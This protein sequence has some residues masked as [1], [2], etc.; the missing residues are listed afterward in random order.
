MFPASI[1]LFFQIE[2]GEYKKLEQFG[3]KYVKIADFEN[4]LK[5]ID[6]RLGIR[7][8][9]PHK[10]FPELEKLASVTVDG[11]SLF[12]I[13]NYD[14]YDE[15]NESYGVDVRGDGRF[16]VH[17]TR[18]EA[19]AGVKDKL[20]QL[21]DPDYADAFFGRGEYS[22]ASLRANPAPTAELI[23]EVKADVVEVT[24]EPKLPK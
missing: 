21:T 19:L 24:S 7:P 8:N 20:K 23:S 12:T 22:E 11:V 4:E 10:L 18:P 13:P 9:Q 17:R 6:P 5:A 16:I 1:D 3:S 14:I 15:R 2:D